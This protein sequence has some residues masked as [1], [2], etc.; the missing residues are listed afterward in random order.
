MDRFD[1]KFLSI[2]E[3]AR[4]LGVSVATLR[5]WDNE[6]SFKASFVTPGGQRRYALSDLE[7]KT[8]GLF[9]LAQE[10]AQSEI[11]TIP[12]N[13]FYCATSDRFKAR[14]ERMANEIVQNDSWQQIASLISSATGEI[15]NNSFDHNLGNWPDIPGIFFT[16]SIR[17]RKVVLA[18]RGQGI[19]TTLKRVRPE[20]LNSG[21]AMKMA[22]TEII[23]GRY[24][25]KTTGYI[26]S[27]LF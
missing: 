1:Q 20:L 5:R 12:E 11:P 17:N 4:Y 9:R 22:F 6:G 3:A 21:E 24:S 15:G 10:W 8:K 23:S 27:S 16:Y 26:I 19:L 13:A 2:K 25:A 18:D 7:M 14:H